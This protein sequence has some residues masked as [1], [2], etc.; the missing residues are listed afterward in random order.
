MSDQ[1]VAE[2][3]DALEKL[4]AEPLEHLDGD[5]IGQWHERFRTAVDAAER[6]P[7]WPG[8]VRRAHDLGQQLDRML[9]QALLQRDALRQELDA[10]GQGARA[11]K[12]YRPR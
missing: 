9:G 2:A 1:V 3:L 12:A 11:L 7:G 5:R 4:L 6:G 10:G 8:L